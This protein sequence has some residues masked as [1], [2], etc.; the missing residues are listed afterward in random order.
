MGPSFCVSAKFQGDGS[1]VSLG[2]HGLSG[3]A[4]E[5]TADAKECFHLILF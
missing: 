4:G 1:A 3:G 5:H 2:H